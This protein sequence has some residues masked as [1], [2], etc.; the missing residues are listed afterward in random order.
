MRIEILDLMAIKPYWNNPKNHESQIED[1]KESI[2]KFGYQ[3]PI[4]VDKKNVIILGHARFKALME[5]KGNILELITEQNA[6]L[7]K[8]KNKDEVERLRSYIANLN[9][10]NEGKV[11]V[12]IAEELGEKKVKE[13]R[14]TD[15]KLNENSSWDNEKLKI[16]L[17]ELEGAI[18]F[19]EAE[20]QKLLQVAEAQMQDYT[21][22]EMDEAAEKME[23]KFDGITKE[24]KDRKIE[25][26]CPECLNTFHMNREDIEKLLSGNIR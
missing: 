1:L 25:I 3:S 14:I 12:V 16:E 10:I 23:T 20:I 15:N 13:Y 5:L 7:E 26:M 11:S 19:S 6:I 21:K 22:Q 4:M 24:Y 2:K 8:T 17:R 9:M 18:G